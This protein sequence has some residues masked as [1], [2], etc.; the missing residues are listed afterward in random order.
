LR[1]VAIQNLAYALPK[2][3]HQSTLLPS[4]RKFEGSVLD[5]F[6]CASRARNDGKTLK[7]QGVDRVAPK[8][9]CSRGSKSGD[10][11]VWECQWPRLPKVFC[12]FFSKKKRLLP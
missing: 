5:C 2:R 1:G 6:A 9:R 8:A 12:F 3:W 10:D 7:C 11:G 4:F